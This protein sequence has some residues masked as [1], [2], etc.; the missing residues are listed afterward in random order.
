M[1]LAIV[2]ISL[3]VLS[4]TFFSGFALRKSVQNRV[5]SLSEFVIAVEDDLPRQLFI[6]GY[7]SIFVME[8]EIGDNRNYLGN[9]GV[10][11]NLQEAFFNGTINGKTQPLLDKIKFSD[12]EKLVQDRARVISASVVFSNPSINITQEDPWNVK[13]IFITD[14]Y[15]ED[16]NGLA[17]WNKTLVSVSYISIQNFTDPVY[18]L[19]TNRE[20]NPK[21]VKT[22]HQT[23]DSNA[24]ISHISNGYYR[25]LTN[26]PS[27]IDRLEGNFVVSNMLYPQYGIESL[28]NVDEIPEAYLQPAG[29]SSVDYLYFESTTTGCSVPS[30]SSS[31]PN[32]RLDNAHFDDYG[33]SC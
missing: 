26:S 32:F 7:R 20:V 15:V 12:L 23:F 27:F 19:N 3:F 13:I 30:V 31:Y 10:Y 11:S 33:V 4:I 9:G 5:E 8:K 22:P 21:I 6:T 14:F 25:N 24:V 28:V 17:S 18:T 2:V 16:S 1:T 29:R